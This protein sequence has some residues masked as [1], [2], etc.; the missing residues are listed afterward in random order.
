MVSGPRERAERTRPLRKAFQEAIENGDL[1]A[2]LSASSELLLLDAIGLSR[3]GRASLDDVYV[4]T[5]GLASGATDVLT[6]LRHEAAHAIARQR[7]IKDTS[8]Q[9]RYHNKRFKAIG[10]E[11]GLVVSCDP[12]VGWSATTLPASVAATYAETV[13]PLADA[14]NAYREC[15]PFGPAS[16][17]RKRR[18]YTLECVCGRRTRDRAK[19]FSAVAFV[20]SACS[21]SSTGSC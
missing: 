9:G 17:P 14:L 13:A 4:T 1:G 6:T 12:P 18:D 20:C 7:G 5:A 3:Q 10:D 8:R 16:G 15:E 19:S 21:V 11:L 2:A